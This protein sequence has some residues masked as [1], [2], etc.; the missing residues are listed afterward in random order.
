MPEVQELVDAWRT[1]TAEGNDT[2]EKLMGVNGAMLEVSDSMVRAA[3]A[4]RKYINDDIDNMKSGWEELQVRPRWK[5]RHRSTCS[6]ES[7]SMKC[8][9][10]SW[11]KKLI[12]ISDP[13]NYAIVP[14][15]PEENRAVTKVLRSIHKWRK[16]LE[17][18]RLH[19]AIRSAWGDPNAPD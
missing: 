17:M 10:A 19:E 14:I 13:F 8:S 3:K 5:K 16:R 12:R 1:S 6:V 7:G 15:W 18:R 2:A 4:D 9:C 11:G